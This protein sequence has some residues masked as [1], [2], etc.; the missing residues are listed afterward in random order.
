MKMTLEQQVE[1]LQQ[2]V[3]MLENRVAML[4]ARGM[5]YGPIPTVPSFPIGPTTPNPYTWP[6]YPP[7]TI[8]C[9]MADGTTKEMTFTTPIV[10]QTNQ[11]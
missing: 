11:C 4:E 10:A 1:S 7:Y 6:G 8:T 3:A 9:K 5:Q 2:R